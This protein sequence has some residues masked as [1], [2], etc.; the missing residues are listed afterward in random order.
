[1]DAAV[2]DEKRGMNYGAALLVFLIC[3]AALSSWVFKND[4]LAGLL[5]AAAAFDVIALFVQRW[6]SKS[7]D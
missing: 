4:I 3:M 2:A 1:M 5:L 7:K 6:R